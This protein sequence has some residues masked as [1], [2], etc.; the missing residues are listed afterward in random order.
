MLPTKLILQEALQT[1][2]KE[3][4]VKSVRGDM[5]EKGVGH[6]LGG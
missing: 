4:E 3:A 1:L 6:G 2:T 5:E